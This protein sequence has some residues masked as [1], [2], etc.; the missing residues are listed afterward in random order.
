MRGDIIASIGMHK[1]FRRS[2][3]GKE[4]R[5]MNDE[6][7]N[8]I[9][10][11]S[12]F[13]PIRNS[14]NPDVDLI[15]GYL[16][17]KNMATDILYIEQE[18]FSQDISKLYKF[19]KF[20][21]YVFYIYPS[22]LEMCIKIIKNLKQKNKNICVCIVGDIVSRCYNDILK[23]SLEIDYIILGTPNKAIYYIA[24]Q[25]HNGKIDLHKYKNIVSHTCFRDRI[26]YED[27]HYKLDYVDDYFEKRKFSLKMC[28]CFLTKS[29]GC[30]GGCTFCTE[31]RSTHFCYAS[32]ESIYQMIINK[33]KNLNINHFFILDDNLFDESDNLA[34]E[35][36]LE[37]CDL[38]IKEKVKVTFSFLMRPDSFQDTKEDHVLLHRMY[39]AGFIQGSFGAEA[40]NN[41][42]LKLYG[43]ECNVADIKRSFELLGKHHIMA[44]PGFIMLNPYSTCKSLKDNYRL[45][46][47]FQSGDLYRFAGSYLAVYKNTSIYYKLNNDNLLRRPYNYLNDRCYMYVNDEI[48]KVARFLEKFFWNDSQL[49]KLETADSLLFLFLKLFRYHSNYLEYQE[50]VN[51]IVCEYSTVLVNY[52]KLLYVDFNLEKCEKNFS[53]FKNNLLKLNDKIV[54][55][56][57]RLMIDYLKE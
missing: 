56:E 35:R 11:V 43:K 22:N 12:V 44:R 50:K 33:K 23:S 21:I 47:E 27:S 38:L 30:S 49:W 4:L 52:F 36:I 6:S 18:F 16:R 28:Y 34:K 14:N 24:C 9:L 41:T 48:N 31:K 37:L 2:R 55:L 54:L 19:K 57:K 26:V 15:V 13:A 25:L 1:P 42:D 40:G 39:E 53:M 29:K 17:R 20:D 32:V 7:R 46:E 5:I 45:L 8:R 3:R 10:V 51:Q